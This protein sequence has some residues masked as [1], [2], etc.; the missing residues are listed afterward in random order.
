MP[1]DGSV[2][3][4]P[5]HCAALR[6]AAR[7]VTQ[8][9]DTALAPIG[10][11]VTQF[12]TLAE[13]D[14]RRKRPPTMGELAEVLGMDRSTLGHSL[15][16]LERDRLIQLTA[17]EEDRRSRRV[18]LTPAGKAKFTE[19]IAFWRKAQECF[20]STYGSESAARLRNVLNDLAALDFT[21]KKLVHLQGKEELKTFI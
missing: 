13:I 3:Q 1:V 9:Y 10:L 12:S 11:T 21:T 6:K 18:F 2:N 7:R 15:R 17:G 8:V 20:E 16:P 4:S 5:C 14:R 19:A